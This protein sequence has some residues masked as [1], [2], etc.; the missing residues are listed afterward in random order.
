M[1]NKKYNY[2]LTTKEFEQLK[3]RTKMSLEDIIINSDVDNW[4][5]GTSVFDQRFF[6]RSNLLFLITD[7][8]GNK[9]GGYINTKIDKL[10]QYGVKDGMRCINDPKSFVFNLESNGRLNEMMKF[11]VKPEDSKR[12]F[13]IYGKND[14]EKDLFEIGWGDLRDYKKN[15]INDWYTS[16]ANSF[17]YGNIKNALS[18]SFRFTVGYKINDFLDSCDL[19]INYEKLVLIWWIVN[20]F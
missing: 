3:D 17:N 8:N 16:T 9:F 7:T 1:V 12:A 13:R 18:G 4:S 20:A 19:F 14:P 6:G 2:E 5:H 10:S 11:D 15:R